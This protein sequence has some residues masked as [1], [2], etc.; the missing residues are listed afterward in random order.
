MRDKNN[1]PTHAFLLRC[2]P[3]GKAPRSD[4]IRW[5]YSLEGV[6]PKRSRQGFDDLESLL[7]FL[8]GELVDD[9]TQ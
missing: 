5:R 2:W 3:E 8:Q 6:L 9:G 1:L 4:E 7:A